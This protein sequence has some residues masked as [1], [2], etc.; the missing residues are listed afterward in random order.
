LRK[1]G[2][3]RRN[4][5]EQCSP[6]KR[7]SEH[8]A[9]VAAEPQAV[10]LNARRGLGTRLTEVPPGAAENSLNFSANCM[11][12]KSLPAWSAQAM[13]GVRVVWPWAGVA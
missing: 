9:D 11:V 12:N 8:G 10:R 3:A 6:T 13:L 7:K 1:S 5:R 2:A 4:N